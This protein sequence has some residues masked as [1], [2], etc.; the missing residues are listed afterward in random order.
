[1]FDVMP[2]HLL[3]WHWLRKW[4]CDVQAKWVCYVQASGAKSNDTWLLVDGRAPA[5]Q[6]DGLV[7]TVVMSSPTFKNWSE[8][9]KGSAPGRC[10]MMHA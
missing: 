2:L 10:G 9:T 7:R 8:Y 3:P 1:M 6:H 5:G 4:V